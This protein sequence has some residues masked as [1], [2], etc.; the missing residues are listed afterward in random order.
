MAEIAP[1][2]IAP[3]NYERWAVVVSPLHGL[4]AAGALPGSGVRHTEQL[5]QVSASLSHLDSRKKEGSIEQNIRSADMRRKA[6]KRNPAPSPVRSHPGGWVLS[7]PLPDGIFTAA[8]NLTAPNPGKVVEL[9]KRPEPAPA[10]T[11]RVF[12]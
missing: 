8:R 3:L 2:N 7:Q 10:A 5:T 12:G 1:L 11:L 6:P 9:Y 4:E